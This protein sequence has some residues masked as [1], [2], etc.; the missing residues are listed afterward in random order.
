MSDAGKEL[1]FSYDITCGVVVVAVVLIAHSSHT[2]THPTVYPSTHSSS[3]CLLLAT[4]RVECIIVLVR[5]VKVTKRTNAPNRPN[6]VSPRRQVGNDCW[7]AVRHCML[8][9]RCVK[10][11]LIGNIIKF[12][13][14]MP[15]SKNDCDNVWVDGSVIPTTATTATIATVQ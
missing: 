1:L 15:N 6:G 10:P 13:C 3:S 8:R 2:L 7:W 12:N 11:R 5:Y 9:Q 4:S 14:E